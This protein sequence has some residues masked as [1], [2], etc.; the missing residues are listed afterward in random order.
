MSIV[1][2]VTDCVILHYDKRFH[3]NDVLSDTDIKTRFNFSASAW[4]AE[5]E[6]LSELRCIKSLRVRIPQSLMN[7]NTTPEKIGRLVD[8]LVRGRR[9]RAAPIG[10]R[11]VAIRKKKS[12]KTT[13]K[14]P[15]KAT[16]KKK[17]SRSR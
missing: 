11:E 12:R 6:A 7:A 16:R 15:R 4:A 13:R 5:A 10:K 17:V 14:K 3:K 1:D 9:Q 2:D 8:K